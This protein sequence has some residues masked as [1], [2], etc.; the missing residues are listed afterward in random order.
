MDIITAIDHDLFLFLHN[1]ARCHFLD[2]FMLLFTGKWIWVP[3]YVALAWMVLRTD[4]NLRGIL[5]LAAIGV[6]IA[7][8]DQTCQGIIRPIVERLRPCHPD[9]AVVHGVTLVD[10]YRSGSFSFPSCHAANSM[11]LAVMIALYA[12]RR[13]LTLS[14]L[15]WAFVH[16]ISR[17]YLAVHFPGDLVAGWLIGAIFATAFYFLWRW[18]AGRLRPKTEKNKDSISRK[19]LLI[20]LGVLGVTV[21]TITV[22]ALFS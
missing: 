22:I 14:I 2:G 9:S 12:R 5:F 7:V 19:T 15:A 17:V 3:F 11:L 10:N 8:T 13:A 1:V 18:G 21:M 6:A 16:S 4:S 20:P